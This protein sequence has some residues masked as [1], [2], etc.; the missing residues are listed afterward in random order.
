MISCGDLGASLVLFGSCV[1]TFS[2]YPFMARTADLAGDASAALATHPA[3][4]GAPGLKRPSRA[5]GTILLDPGTG[6]AWELIPDPRHP[7]GPGLLIRT[8]H[9][10]RPS[11]PI[12]HPIPSGSP[13]SVSI[14]TGD[15]IV[16]EDHTEAADVRLNAVALAPAAVGETFFA[17]LMPSG[18]VVRAI[19]AAQGC[20]RLAP[21]KAERP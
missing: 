8:E 18:I 11:T 20:A 16:V 15:S 10:P 17:K 1:A 13:A 12:S 19:A 3:S 9:R 4:P 14:R 2:Q 21:L 6:E 7:G 5:A